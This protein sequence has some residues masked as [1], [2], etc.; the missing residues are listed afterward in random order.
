MHKFSFNFTESELMQNKCDADDL[1][2]TSLTYKYGD[3]TISSVE[4]ER[5]NQFPKP[6]F[7][8]PKDCEGTTQKIDLFRAK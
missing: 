7:K 2:A 5:I 4:F 6:L 1:K 8:I 3:Y